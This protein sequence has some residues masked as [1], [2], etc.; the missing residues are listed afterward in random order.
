MPTMHANS[1]IFSENSIE[2]V[3][4][5]H[6]NP[7]YLNDPKINDL[8]KEDQR[9]MAEKIQEQRL[10]PAV[11]LV[12]PHVAMS[13]ARGLYTQGW[14]SEEGFQQILAERR[15]AKDNKI[16]QDNSSLET[17]HSLYDVSVECL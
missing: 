14:I 1:R 3:E 15:N 5:N 2:K 16:V 7:D 17:R 11:F 9:A 6:H 13:L 10:I 8:P 12:K 4:Y